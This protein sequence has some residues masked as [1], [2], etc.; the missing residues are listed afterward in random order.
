MRLI[1]ALLVLLLSALVVTGQYKFKTKGGEFYPEYSR[2]PPSPGQ[3]GS[4][5]TSTDVNAGEQFDNERLIS[6]YDFKV[7][8]GHNGR[9][10]DK[11]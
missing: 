2:R 9:K 6:D 1:G 10:R 8:F 3:A 4:I 7:L 11:R 5:T